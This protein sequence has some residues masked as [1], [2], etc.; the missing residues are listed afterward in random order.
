MGWGQDDRN[1]V[2]TQQNKEANGER[3]LVTDKFNFYEALA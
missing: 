2:G 1:I 3:N